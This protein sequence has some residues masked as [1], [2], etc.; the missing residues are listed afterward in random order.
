MQN[1]R[2]PWWVT[3]VVLL[4]TFLLIMGAVLAIIRPQMLVSP[5]DIVN[6]AAHIYAMYFASRNLALA[7]MLML[8]LSLGKKAAMSH[9]LLLVG[10]IQLLDTVMDCM[11]GRWKVV[12][13]II[14]LGSLCLL[15]ATR[16]V[17]DRREQ[18]TS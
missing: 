11:D 2:I 6:G 3:T 9:T 18:V 5:Q 7:I 15:A 17:R 1:D 10:L 14:V 8:W 13:G 4:S 16:L 12:P